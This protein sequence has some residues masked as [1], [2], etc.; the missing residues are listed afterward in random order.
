MG[1]SNAF[2]TASAALLLASHGHGQTPPTSIGQGKND[3]MKITYLTKSPVTAPPLTLKFLLGRDVQ[4]TEI[5]NLPNGK[6]VKASDYLASVIALEAKLNKIGYSVTS[7]PRKELI[8][9][10][11]VDPDLAKSLQS[12]LDGKIAPGTVQ[13]T[14]RI[15]ITRHQPIKLNMTDFDTGKLTPVEKTNFANSIQAFNQK[16]YVGDMLDGKW[17]NIAQMK[18]Q[19]F[20]D[21]VSDG[22]S[23][24]NLINPPPPKVLPPAKIFRSITLTT[25]IIR[26]AAGSRT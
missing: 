1:N 9:R 7:G 24:V 10:A 19:G 17:V 5:I 15:G 16:G 4:P 21:V 6:R 2:Y 18:A 13:G 12:D 20:H 26:Q 3:L 11:N 14:R 22:I 25:T 23:V 8:T